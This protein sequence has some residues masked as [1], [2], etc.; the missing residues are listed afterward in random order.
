MYKHQREF[1]IFFKDILEAI[2][3]IER[4]TDSLTI[5]QALE[6]EMRFDAILKNLENIGEAANAIPD[7]IKAKYSKIPYTQIY[8]L[9]NILSHEYFGIDKE[10]IEKI[11]QDD[12]PILKRQVIEVLNSEK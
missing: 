1:I 4:Y 12:L 6:E 7:N 9:R 8:R 11:I 2:L 10:E 5:A 3:K